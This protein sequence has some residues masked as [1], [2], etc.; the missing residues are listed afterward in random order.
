VRA[1]RGAAARLR[2]PPLSAPRPKQSERADVDERPDRT[3]RTVRA[4]LADGPP[5][6]RPKR[7]GAEGGAGGAPLGVLGE[8]EAR[9]E[10]GAEADAD[11]DSDANAD[12]DADADSDTDTEADADSEPVALELETPRRQGTRWL[13]M[14]AEHIG[15]KNIVP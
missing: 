10:T 11:V 5:T 4:S 8:S 3:P 13:T 12:A 1:L 15:T 7:S 6:T 9:A 2:S 14:S